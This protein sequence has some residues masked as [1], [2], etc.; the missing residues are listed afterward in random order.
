MQIKFDCINK[1]Q[2]FL[3]KPKKAGDMVAKIQSGTVN[4]TYKFI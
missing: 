2:P 4:E 1:K 3:G